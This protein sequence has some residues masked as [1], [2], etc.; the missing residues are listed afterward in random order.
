MLKLN[1]KMLLMSCLLTGVI[2][3]VFAEYKAILVCR[4][5]GIIH[6]TARSIAL[7]CG[8][9]SEFECKQ[10]FREAL[11]RKFGS[12]NAET[13]ACEQTLGGHWYY[14]SIIHDD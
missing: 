12:Y 7:P 10:T 14:D 2:T 9:M 4:T 13:K 5:Q 1:K 11:E 8:N 6:D 3:P